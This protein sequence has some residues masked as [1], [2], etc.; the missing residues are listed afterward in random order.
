MYSSFDGS[1]LVR[2]FET[3]GGDRVLAWRS[4]YG[5]VGARVLRPGEYVD[6]QTGA[7][8]TTGTRRAR[9]RRAAP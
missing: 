7:V 5:V 3:E 9:R 2:E 1:T 6:Q 8:R 4:P